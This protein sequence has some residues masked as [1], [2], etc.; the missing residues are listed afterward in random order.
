MYILIERNHS[1]IYPTFKI[2][3]M[4][5]LLIVCLAIT[6]GVSLY[7]NINCI[8]DLVIENRRLELVVEADSLIISNAPAEEIREAKLAI[9]DF[10]RRHYGRI[11]KS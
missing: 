3:F 4:K 11:H 6:L 10:D 7:K 9:I 2:H 8:N 1:H 5:N